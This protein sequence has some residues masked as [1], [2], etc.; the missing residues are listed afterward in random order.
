MNYHIFFKKCVV[1]LLLT[2]IF[3]ANISTVHGEAERLLINEIYPNPEEGGGEWLEL[4]NPS[5][6]SISLEGFSLTD[7]SGNSIKPLSGSIEAKSFLL[8][9]DLI[10]V[11][12]NDTDSVYLSFD[13]NIIDQVSYG[14][15]RNNPQNAP[16]PPR[17]KSISRVP[18]GIDSGGDANDFKVVLPTPGA[19]YE[20]QAYSR[21]II[22]SEISPAPSDGSSNEFIELYNKGQDNIN[23]KYWYLDDSEGGSSVYSIDSDLIIEPSA[24]MAF[25]NSETKIALNDDGDVARLFDPNGEIVSSVIYEKAEKGSS[26]SLF[27]NAWVWTTPTPGQINIAPT[28]KD[29]LISN[30]PISQI[31]KLEDGAKVITEG[32][33]SVLPGILSTQYFYIQDQDSGIQI[34][35]YNKL[36][37]QFKEG[38]QIRVN[39]E[40]STV[41]GERR[42]KTDSLEDFSIISNG[43]S[44]VPIEISS[45]DVSDLIVGKY[46]KINGTVK[47]TS[48]KEFILDGDTEIKVVIRDGT[49][50]VKPRMEKGDRVIICGIL[51][52]YN[53]TFRLLPIRQNDVTII[54]SSELPLVGPSLL[55]YVNIN[56]IVYLIFILWNIFLRARKKLLQSQKK[57]HQNAF[58]VM[59]MHFLVNLEA[60]KLP[61]PR[62]LQRKWA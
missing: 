62:V 52:K 6:S 41:S 39:G 7:L 38:D 57:L 37:A 36:F 4:Y 58:R 28:I 48:G 23:L 47:S 34:Y 30:Q 61:S 25:Y 26:Y 55:E 50:I 29:S 54:T 8:V 17:G 44:V 42:I 53:N 9:S 51:S 27:E 56:L 3:F 35:S 14:D 10:F 5:D 40:L 45:Q 60:E 21:D 11:L 32:V 19:K 12:N 46:V 49:G 18:D 15:I 43:N 2:N 24:Y 59:F 16:V 31:K 20:E 22:I 13:S 33:I 1:C